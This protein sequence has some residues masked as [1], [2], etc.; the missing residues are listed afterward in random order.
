MPGDR[1]I[2]SGSVTSGTLNIEKIEIKALT[3]ST[4]KKTRN[5]LP[6]ENI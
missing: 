4:G 5:V 3:P 6:A 1:V 2:L